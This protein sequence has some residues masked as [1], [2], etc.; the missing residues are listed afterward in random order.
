MKKFGIFLFGVITGILLMFFVAVILNSIDDADNPYNIS[1]LSMLP[2][3]GGCIAAGSIE[4][5]QTLS[6]G[7]AL[8][9][10]NANY[11]KIVLLLNDNEKLFY[12]GEKIKIPAK[13][14]AKQIGTY[15]YETKAEFQKTVP[16][17][18]IE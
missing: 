1:G 4:I 11:N 17:V 13:K 6:K 15:T 8:A 10:P 2:E 12:D 3:K 5:F 18:I 14:C 16:A 9:H 7:V